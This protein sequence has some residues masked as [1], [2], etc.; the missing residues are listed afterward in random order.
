MVIGNGHKTGEELN[1]EFP[2]VTLNLRDLQRQDGLIA[3]SIDKSQSHNAGVI[4][5]FINA[6]N[7]KDYRQILQ[8]A[9]WRNFEEADKATL[10]LATCDMTG[11]KKAAHYILDRITSHQ[12]GEKGYLMGKAFEALTHTTFTS[13]SI[14]DRKKKQEH[15][16]NR[17]SGTSSL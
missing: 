1:N 6:N 8:H 4:P 10:A 14:D 3:E 16:R 15:E 5:T 11:A 2:G 12:G 7:D 17:V 9:Y 13:N